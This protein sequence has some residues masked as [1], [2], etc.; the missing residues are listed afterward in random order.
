VFKS[1]VTVTGTEKVDGDGNI[2][3]GG[4]SDGAVGKG[5]TTGSVRL[6]SGPGTSYSSVTTMSRGTEVTIYGLTDGWYSVKLANGAAGYAS[7]KYITVTESYGSME[8]S[9]SEETDKAIGAGQ[10]TANLNFRQ[11]PS[12]SSRKI[13]T[14]PK[15]TEVT[16]YS[17]D[18]GWYQAEY[19]GARGYLS[20]KYITRT[21][22]VGG[23]DGVAQVGGSDTVI[24]T[25]GQ[26]GSA[27]TLTKGV[28]TANVNFRS[29]PN[30]SGTKVYKTLDEGTKVELIGQTGSWYYAIYDGQAGFLNT[31]YVSIGE[32]G[33]VGVQPVSSG[34]AAQSCKTN[35][36]V[37][38]RTGPSTS[39]SKITLLPPG[40]ALTAYYVT[41]EWCFVKCNGVYG[42]AFDEYI[43]VA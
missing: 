28:T 5:V 3:G 26:S 16:L 18:D 35:A 15:G 1:Y 8:E 30:T 24:S 9:G 19:K 40:T 10:T 41:G 14:L 38:L 32:V 34:I 17:L 12:T 37:N 27:V 33:S 11:G 7:S 6:R 42:F 31:A 29:G 22:Q 23:S 25:E 21:A 20:A 43:S 36:Q 2:I 4:G 13:T 39:H